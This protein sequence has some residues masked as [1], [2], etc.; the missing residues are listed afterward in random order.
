MRR[1][2]TP[3]LHGAIDYVFLTTMLTVPTALGLPPRARGLFAAF[4]AIQGSLN[5]VTDQPLALARR[6]PFRTHGL[7]EK[8]SG[9]LYVGLP[10]A[11]G[12]LRDSRTRAFFAV[13]GAVLVTVYNLTDWNDPDTDH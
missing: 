11:T 8:S 1:P 9:P 12:I 5:A 13:M 3:K 7:I 10:A 6:V 2:I 4:G